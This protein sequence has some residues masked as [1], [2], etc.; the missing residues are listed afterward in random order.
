MATL[1][2]KS[3]ISENNMESLER[4]W[5]SFVCAPNLEDTTFFAPYFCYSYVRVNYG[6]VGTSLLT[7]IWTP[8]FL[9]YGDRIQVSD[10]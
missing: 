9:I 7:R 8:Q 5:F 1:A 6:P 10:W 3:S 4:H 2:P